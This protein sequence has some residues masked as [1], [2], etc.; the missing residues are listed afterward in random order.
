MIEFQFESVMAFFAMTP[1][2]PFVWPTYA[3]GLV[4][5]V[6]LTFMVKN[7]HRRALRRIRRQVER[8]AS[9]ESEA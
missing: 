6:A 8:E 7:G 5:L 1:H 4:T 9:H 2:G 3:L